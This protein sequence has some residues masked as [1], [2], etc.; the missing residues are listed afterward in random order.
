MQESSVSN[1]SSI[2]KLSSG[3]IISES[4][5]IQ[6]GIP[7]GKNL[8]LCSP[9]VPSNSPEGLSCRVNNVREERLEQVD[10]LENEDAASLIAQ[11]DQMK[12]DSSHLSWDASEGGNS[13]PFSATNSADS[14]SSICTMKKS[15]SYAGFLE[16]DDVLVNCITVSHTTLSPTVKRIQIL[17][18][19]VPLYLCC[20]GLMIHFGVSTK[21]TDH[22]GRPKFSILVD[23]PP[24]LCHVLSI[25]DSLVQNSLRSHG[26]TSEWWPLMR[27]NAYTNSS[28]VRLHIR[29][30]TNWESAAMY[31]TEIYRIDASKNIIDKLVLSKF[32]AAELDLLFTPGTT[33]DAFFCL[34]AYDYQQNA[35]IRLV[36]K[37]LVLHSIP[38]SK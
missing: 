36:A 18:L 33:I 16:P 21:F 14:I 29:S 38:A 28:T 23:A 19:N 6:K 3:S 9:P 26:S 17:H 37:S 31:Y 2:K 25:C 4:C 32:D 11:V 22:A 7:L 5:N 34:D 27:K 13:A 15:S 12:I 8:K 20:G 1:A 10:P 24:S 35:G 30:R